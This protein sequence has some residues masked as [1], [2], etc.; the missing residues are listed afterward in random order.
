MSLSIRQQYHNDPYIILINCLLG[1]RTRDVVALPVS[2]QLFLRAR[3]PAQMLGLS[4]AELEKI[5]HSVGFYRQKARLLHSVS[6]ELIERFKGKVPQTEKELLSI[7][8]VGR[9]TANLVRGVAFGIPA[10]CVD[11][12]VHRLANQLG[13][14]HTKTPDQTEEALKH[15]VPKR[16][17]TE[18]NALL[19]MWGQQIPRRQQI[20]LLLSY[21][22]QRKQTK[23]STK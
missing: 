15:I 22:A 23:K 16:Y 17:W 2:Q 14:V 20:P 9:K 7:K 13:L 8:G 5:V 4:V 6:K 11:T 19:V 21:V 1:L 3:T 18:L 10:I 12:H